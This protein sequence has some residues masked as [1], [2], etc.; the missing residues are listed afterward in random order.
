MNDQVNADGP[1][2]L[3]H[4]GKKGMKWGT[5]KAARAENNSK[6]MTAR[7]NQAVREGQLTKLTAQRLAATS[8][9]G[10]AKIDDKI[11]DKSFEIKH[12]PDAR[13]A[14]KL[15]SGEKWLKGGKAAAMLG[16]SLGGLGTVNNMLNSAESK[17]F[18]DGWNANS[19]FSNAQ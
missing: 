6:I 2:H 7:G 17:S 1:D 9:V 16:L 3:A 15:T 13:Q 11:S 18:I 4:Y 5:R 12:H 19:D 8:R 14:A 10:K